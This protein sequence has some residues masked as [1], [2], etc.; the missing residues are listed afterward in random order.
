MTVGGL[1]SA[2]AACSPTAAVQHP[3]PPPAVSATA[4]PRQEEMRD[5]LAGLATAGRFTGTVL[6]ARGDHRFETALGLADRAHDEPDTV[7]TRYRLGSVTTQFTAATVLVLQAQ[8]R[9]A[10]P[11]R[12]CRYLPDCPASWSAITIEQLLTHTSGIPDYLVVLSNDEATDV[13]TVA[14]QLAALA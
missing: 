10:V 7:G 11:D 4:F 2:L 9:L 8:H 5:H 3:G 1:V 6:V 14:Q 13:L 12:I